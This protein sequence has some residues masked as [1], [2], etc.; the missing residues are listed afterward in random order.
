M[1][2]TYKF[3]RAE[4]E[5]VIIRGAEDREWEAYTCLPSDARKFQKQGW[6]R[7]EEHFYEDGSFCW[8]KYRARL[9]ALR[10]GRAEKREMTPEERARL[11]ALLQRAREE[12]RDQEQ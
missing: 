5:T 8:G 7:V 1:D 4:Q 2:Q 10:I 3:S 11:A 9:A 12:N 6:E